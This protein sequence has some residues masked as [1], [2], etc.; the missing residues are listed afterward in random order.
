MSE[1]SQEF[2]EGEEDRLK[3]EGLKQLRI[4][5]LYEIIEYNLTDDTIGNFQELLIHFIMENEIPIE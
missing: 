5:A 1:S 4:S 3:I 2:I